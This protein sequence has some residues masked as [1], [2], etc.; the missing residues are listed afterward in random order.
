M[1]FSVGDADDIGLAGFLLANGDFIEHRPAS[2]VPSSTAMTEPRAR[3]F[4]CMIL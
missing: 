2:S 1:L 3:A 4:L